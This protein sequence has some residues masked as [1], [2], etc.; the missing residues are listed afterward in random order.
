MSQYWSRI[1]SS[2]TMDFALYYAHM[3]QAKSGFTVVEIIVVI[4]IVGILSVIGIVGFNAYR[5]DTNVAKI[6]REM[7]SIKLGIDKYYAKNGSYP[8]RSSWSFM[9]SEGVGFIPGLS[10]EYVANIN[11]VPFGSTASSTANTYAY[12][13]TGSDYKLI[14]LAAAGG[15][16]LETYEIQAI[17]ADMQDVDGGRWTGTVKRGW[18]YWTPGAN[19]W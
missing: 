9:R 19:S 13:S 4:V 7:L 10:P 18:G 3:R 5:Q 1:S 14:R 11:D 8:V 12:R 17:S 16:S 6:K 15:A 2:S